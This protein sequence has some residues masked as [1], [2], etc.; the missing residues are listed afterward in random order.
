MRASVK[1]IEH[2]RTG[3]AA[4]DRMAFR[5][6]PQVDIHLHAQSGILLY[7]ME[8]YG[9]VGSMTFVQRDEHQPDLL[10][11][12][13]GAGVA[14]TGRIGG[15]RVE[16]AANRML[17]TTFIP[18][19]CDMDLRFGAAARSTNLLFP[20][21]YLDAM[22]APEKSGPISP[23]LYSSDDRLPRLIKLLEQ[24]IV[25]P[26]FA[27]DLL[28]ESLV[29]SLVVLIKQRGQQIA[30]AAPDRLYMSPARLR[31]V[32]D[33]IESHLNQPIHLAELA[34]T[35]G[36]SIFHFCRTFKCATGASPYHYV[37]QRRIERGRELLANSC[38]PIAEL[39]LACGFSNQSH[40][41]AAFSKEFGI[42]PNRYRRSVANR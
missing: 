3:H 13:R 31:R 25:L 34:Q 20:R 14:A 7:R 5:N 39:A 37:S 11:M 38:L 19:G 24:E 42:S 28:V 30:P 6:R 27:S 1:G 12:S 2:T 29:R 21:G 26:G 16:V 17:R 4:I 18:T 15:D 32:I 23:V 10:F 41:T 8:N 36:M 22:T 35:A 40:F 33:Y 9:E